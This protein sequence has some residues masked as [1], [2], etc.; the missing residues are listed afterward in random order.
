[1]SSLSITRQQ[2]ATQ[3]LKKIILVSGENFS[4]EGDRIFS[5][6]IPLPQFGP[7]SVLVESNGAGG[8]V[9]QKTVRVSR[10]QSPSLTAEQ[11]TTT[12]EG[13]H[14]KVTIAVKSEASG[15]E[16]GGLW[17]AVT[18][19]LK[20]PA[21]G[22]K[23]VT[24]KTNVAQLGSDFVIGA[25][26]LG[27]N[28]QL[29]VQV[30]NAATG[31]ESD[32]CPTVNLPPLVVEQEPFA[33]EVIAPDPR[34][35]RHFPAQTNGTLELAFRLR[36]KASGTCDDSVQ[37]QFNGEEPKSICVNPEGIYSQ[38][39]HPQEGFN[40]AQIEA[41]NGDQKL[42]EN[43]VFGWGKFLSP[44]DASGQVRPADEWR[45]ADAMSLWL[46]K[47]GLE[48]LLPRLVENFLHS[49][50]MA[51]PPSGGSPAPEAKSQFNPSALLPYCTLS[52]GGGASR[53]K[54]KMIKSLHVGALTWEPFDFATDRLDFG[55][56]VQNLSTAIQ[57]YED[58]NNDG[59]PDKDPI[60]LKVGFAHLKIK[61][62]LV[63]MDFPG[64]RLPIFESDETDCAYKREGAC[65]QLPALVTPQNYVG[66]AT[67][68]GAFVACDHS[69]GVSEKMDGLC[70]A[71]NA[72]DY[73]WGPFLQERVLDTINRAYACSVPDAVAKFHQQGYP[74]SKETE[75][76]ALAG[77]VGLDEMKIEEHG[78]GA[79]LFTRF[80]NAEDFAK[81]PEALRKNRPGI[82]LA[83]AVGKPE[84]TNTS[85]QL[86]FSIRLPLLSQV[87]WGLEAAG[88]GAFHLQ[89]DDAF[90]QERGID[91]SKV[92][93]GEEK[94]PLCNVRPR[95]REILGALPGQNGYFKDTDPLQLVI[96]PAKI[97]P[98]SLGV[99][100]AAGGIRLE[101]Y[102]WDVAIAREGETLLHA[103]ISF[104]VVVHFSNPKLT[105]EDPDH[106]QV[107]A[108]LDPTASHFWVTADETTNRTFIPGA[109][110]LADLREK[111]NAA[112]EVF[113]QPGK[114]QVIRIPRSFW[115]PWLEGGEL[116]KLDDL[117]VKFFPTE[118]A[119]R[120][121][122]P[123]P[124]T[125]SP[126]P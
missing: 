81:W 17:V 82:Y 94:N 107:T 30:C 101:G 29:S 66:N 10:V 77:V 37:I 90:F 86:A 109:L 42:S 79:A 59:V 124:P 3:E 89:L 40:S 2:E 72:L 78:V 112:V 105:L 33:I 11:I 92:C 119:V 63:M 98:L 62:R 32:R 103:K 126:Q 58:E 99:V 116:W 51:E 121:L 48:S 61:P 26:V 55:L 111:L 85:N 71:I 108:L 74:F 12:Q 70:N 88:G 67:S 106:F 96:T 9:E 52:Q 24:C 4:M 125:H 43:I 69:I 84:L 44:F 56:A 118:N 23:W 38:I 1:M 120:I 53:Q 7:Y 39:L 123:V 5:I 87:V 93:D 20:T 104:Q 73:T 47:E 100:D 8:A 46:P 50:F 16:T 91:F 75:S 45:L 95:V 22:E 34:G 27:G 113:S 65:F 54:T 21:G 117:Q 13:D 31:F 122:T 80:G 60:P 35:P 110:M 102:D 68:A 14:T 49:E 41:K 97:F 57:V 115:I 36:G 64:M 15:V 28:N 6:Q 25:P 114:E 18:N 76:V 19:R 83:D